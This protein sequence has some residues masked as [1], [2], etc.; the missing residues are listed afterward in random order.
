MWSSL[1]TVIGV[2]SLVV[3]REDCSRR[4]TTYVI[5]RSTVIEL[6]RMQC[7]KRMSL[8]AFCH[9]KVSKTTE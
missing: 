9:C 2:A 8:T 3:W 5:S 6:S 1:I 7:V 4:N